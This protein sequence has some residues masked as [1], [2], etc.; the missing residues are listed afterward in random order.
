MNK[1]Q[2][3]NAIFSDIDKNPYLLKIYE[4]LLYNNAIVTMKIPQEKKDINLEDALRFADILSKS[5]HPTKSDLHK[6]WSQEIIILLNLLFP[7]NYDVKL[8]MSNILESCGN[9]RGLQTAKLSYEASNFFDFLY[10]DAN[11]ELLKIPG[12]NSAYF[13]PIQKEIMRNLNNQYFSYSGPTSLG[14]S[15]LVQTYI[16]LKIEN[17][18]VDN[19]AIV[20]PTKAL[21]NE[22]RNKLLDDMK[23]ILVKKDYKIITSAADILLQENHHF[24]FVFTPERLT[25]LLSIYP[26]LSLGLVF[27]DEAHKITN[28]DRRSIY[29]YECIGSL[30]K[31]ISNCSFIFASP[32][33][34]NPEVFFDLFVGQCTTPVTITTSYSPVTQFKYLIDIPNRDF[35]YFNNISSNLTKIY[36][37]NKDVNLSKLINI[38]GANKQNLVYVNSQVRVLQYADDYIETQ[39]LQNLDDDELNKF[40]D[41][42]ADEIG[43]NF[44]LCELIKKG[45]AYHVGYLPANIKTRIEKYYISGKIKTIFC[46]STLNEG[47]NLPADNLFITNYSNGRRQMN[48][49][50]FKNLI[51]RVGRINTNLYGNVFLICMQNDKKAFNEYSTLLKKPIP[52][53]HLSIEKQLTLKQ[54]KIIVDSLSKGD[55]E[56]CDSLEKESNPNYTIMRATA[57]SLAKSI[58]TDTFTAVTKS[59]ENLL[60]SSTIHKIKDSFK[61]TKLSDDIFFSYDQLENLVIAIRNGAKYPELGDNHKENRKKIAEFLNELSIIFKWKSYE[62]K[63]LGKLGKTDMLWFAIML[64]QWMTGKPIKDLIRLAQA[65]CS[66]FPYDGVKIGDNQIANFYDTNNYAHQNFA[67][68]DALQKIEN[69]ILFT[70]ASYFRKFTEVYKDINGIDKLDNNWY[71]YIE[72]GTMNPSIKKLQQLGFSRNSSLYIW[73]NK[74]KYLIIDEEHFL[75]KLELLNSDNESV[76]IEVNTLVY[77]I[78]DYFDL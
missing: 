65:F 45:V 67:I 27:V 69:T 78:I 28:K 39:K 21:I 20:V 54:K 70:I 74:D 61:N 51:G 36:K 6:M 40:A 19:F 50:E 37:S 12:I 59:F 26:E 16:K 10:N 3:G 15:F 49:V 73:D 11:K 14:K 62:K 66:K 4:N 76:K 68:A 46:T 71:E 42:I 63:Y 41:D 25:N 48:E 24:I 57:L 56:M 47:V 22:V 30:T 13:F 35:F 9:Y 52:K 43:P 5:N 33:I 64:E 1:L 32:N 29:Y 8:Y 23:E 18:C 75:L 77:N 38:L 58:M 60:D 17:N 7:N 44:Y 31:K 55:V 2:L 34:P 72:Y 53:Q